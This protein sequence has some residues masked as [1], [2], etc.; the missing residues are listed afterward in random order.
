MQKAEKQPRIMKFDSIHKMFE[1]G[2]VEQKSSYPEL[3]E[4]KSD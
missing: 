2:K 4:S 3:V 1:E